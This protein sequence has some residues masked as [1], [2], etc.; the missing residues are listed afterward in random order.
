M[1][2]PIEDQAATENFA[3]GEFE[4]LGFMAAPIGLVITENWVIQACNTAFADMFG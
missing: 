4:A 2:I 3:L 1:E